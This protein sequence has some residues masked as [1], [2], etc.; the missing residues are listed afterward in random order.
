VRIYDFVEGA[1]GAAISMEYVDGDTLASL[2][3]DQPQGHFEPKQLEAWLKELC[4]ALKYAH[5][6][7]QVVHRDLK[8]ANF[9][10]DS[11]GE[12]K[13]ADFG[14]AAS[15]SESVSRV[16]VQAGTSGTPVYM[17]PQQMM[18]EKPTVTDDIYAL[19][20]T[21]FDLLTSKP[22]F[23]AGNV[24]LQVMNKVAPTVADRRVELEVVGDEIPEAWERTIAACL[25]KEPEARPKSASEVAE[26]L[27][28]GGSTDALGISSKTQPAM[29]TPASSP[30]ERSSAASDTPASVALD[31]GNAKSQA[32]G[33][34]KN[35][36]GVWGSAVL[37]LAVL[38]SATGWYFK[39]HLPEQA[40]REASRV[41][42]AR[43]AGEEAA[44]AQAEQAR[45]AKIAAAEQAKEDGEYAE[46]VAQIAGVYDGIG[47]TERDRV[48]AAVTNYVASAPDRYR[49]DVTTRWS[50]R[51]TAWET[52]RL[53][54]ARGGL[55]VRTVPSD[56]EVQVGSV[57]LERS[58]VTLQ[59]VRLGTYPLVIKAE[60]YDVWRGEIEVKENEFADPDPIELVRSTGRLSLS[61]NVREGTATVEL[62]QKGGEGI[63][64][65]GSL[66]WEDVVLPTG[67]YLVAA[68]SRGLEDIEQTV[69]VTAGISK[70]VALNFLFGGI[71]IDSVPSGSEVC[72]G[73][74]KWGVTPLRIEQHPVGSFEVSLRQKGYAR[75]KLGGV[76][77]SGELLQLK[78][79]LK[80]GGLDN[81]ESILAAGWQEA[82]LIKDAEARASVLL[83]LATMAVKLDDASDLPL[84]EV[85][86]D[87]L[88][89]AK[90]I[91][92]QGKRLTTLGGALDW[93]VHV[94]FEFSRRYA[95]EMAQAVPLIRDQT[96]RESAWMWAGKM[97]MHPQEAR[98]ALEPMINWF[99][100]SGN[101]WIH[102]VQI[103][104]A[105][106]KIGETEAARR[107]GKMAA[108]QYREQAIENAITGGTKHRLFQPVLLSL[109][110]NDIDTA[111]RQFA[112]ISGVIDYANAA[113]L[114]NE[115]IRYEEFALL[116]AL[117]TQ[118]DPTYQPYFPGL[119]VTYATMYGEFEF[120][121]RIAAS[122]RDGENVTT[123]SSAYHTLAEAYLSAG[124]IDLARTAALR[125]K[126]HDAAGMSRMRLVPVLM[127]VGET[128]RAQALSRQVPAITEENKY[129]A[130]FA[131]PMYASL[132]DTRKYNDLKRHSVDDGGALM[133][134]MALSRMGLLDEAEKLA[135]TIA[136]NAPYRMNAFFSITAARVQATPQD[137]WNRLLDE[138]PSVERRSQ[139]Y[140]AFLQS[141]MHQQWF[142]KT[143]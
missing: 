22:P 106:A 67:E 60:G 119:L 83:G 93:V 1:S 38:G 5:N 132:G 34:K 14:I 73:D 138:A 68:R 17:S 110:R 70:P 105:Y 113:D 95:E 74:Q 76:V 40:R 29:P 102:L 135:N 82:K 75:A 137:D 50:Q 78:A 47:E 59:E 120:A 15:V 111:R 141:L 58:P 123:Q 4:G 36:K 124:E 99:D 39:V 109:L 13:I 65:E 43:L 49:T 79:E 32:S 7:A 72:H 54:M 128:T 103:A 23:Y 62:W 48:K 20:A 139:L 28:L 21:L 142:G 84:L 94:D 51:L 33:P 81:A 104:G 116:D 133:A 125:V 77:G 11:R 136:D 100:G 80:E 44:R 16:S 87:H 85:F 66:P 131:A 56:V 114:A 57:A 10:I 89:A 3:V 69:E 90:Q 25:A 55:R 91:P 63:L 8:P 45:L 6:R 107:V 12:L 96:V 71:E 53:S 27:G 130:T 46:I 143:S 9:M 61:T 19:G 98:R 64:E 92:D 86:Q 42:E 2:K 37:A 97:W 134:S 26:L 31:S 115:F 108:G 140:M 101:S 30:P 35:F 122:V 129:L 117:Q 118:L 121:E 41:E 127:G 24:T 52:H 112:Q 126:S 18:G 88:A